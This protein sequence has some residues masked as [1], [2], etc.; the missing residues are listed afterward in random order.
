ML[1]GSLRSQVDKIWRAF[2][3][4]GFSNL[5]KVIEWR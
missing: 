4:G 1:T 5:L 2:W 3:S